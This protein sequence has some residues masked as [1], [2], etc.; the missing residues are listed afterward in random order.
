LD[1]HQKLGLSQQK[2]RGALRSTRRAI[3]VAGHTDRREL[4]ESEQR[5]YD[6]M[7]AR[8]SALLTVAA[9]RG[10]PQLPTMEPTKAAAAK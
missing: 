9:Q 4:T 2:L 10:T 7:T 1:D 8:A 5:Q 6:H 3:R